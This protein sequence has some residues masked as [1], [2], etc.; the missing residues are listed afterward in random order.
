MQQEWT[1]KTMI[2]SISN[3]IRWTFAHSSSS[4]VGAMCLI[5]QL[6]KEDILIRKNDNDLISDDSTQMRLSKKENIENDWL[7]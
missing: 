4:E 7:N 1:K 2:K 3:T 6:D 5:H